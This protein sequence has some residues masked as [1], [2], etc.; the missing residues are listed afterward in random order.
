MSKSSQNFPWSPRVRSRL[1]VV[2]PLGGPSLTQSEWKDQCDINHQIALF[3]RA[4]RPLPAYG[5][6]ATVEH[7]QDVNA[8]YVEAFN[9]SREVEEAFAQLPSKVRTRFDNSPLKLAVFLADGVNAEEAYE[10]GLTKSPPRPTRPK[11]G[12]TAP[13]PPP[14]EPP[15]KPL[16]AGAD[17]PA[18]SPPS[19]G[20]A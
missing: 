20:G 17:A 3:K 14:P 12:D 15:A 7:V 11:L 2:Q 6:D 18:T 16:K 10:L 5:Q 9:A 4:G 8:T 19:S 1:R 13:Q